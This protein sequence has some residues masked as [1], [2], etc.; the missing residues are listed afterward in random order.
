MGLPTISL[1]RPVFAIVMN[2][3]IVLFGII[4]Y[5][6]LGVREYPSIDP[7]VITV[8]TNYTGANADI[9]ETQITEPLEKAINGVE[10]I[11]TV[12][13]ASNQGSSIITV[14]F[15]LSSDLETAANDVRDKVSQA[16]RQLPQDIDAPPVV[17][18]ADANSDA[19]ISMTVQS[20]TRNI[21][22]LN[23]YAVNVLQ[24]R[25]QTIPGVSSV[26][27]WG[28]KNYSMRLWMDP[29]KM[30]AYGL[31]PLDIQ[32]ALNSENVELP[33]GKI[34]GSSVDLTVKTIG[35]LT[36]E[37][38]FNNLLLKNVNGAS[39]RLKDVGYATLGPENEE[40]SLKE[41][42]IPMVALALV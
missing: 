26:Q 2:I 36:T 15:D 27:I 29:Q 7:P 42:A 33:S 18:K 17:S 39:V 1:Q 22:E 20:N 12:S 8:R 30:A 23:D 3:V 35:R 14:E 41:S 40:T 13:S 10:G 4:G 6:F 11:R 32:N 9:I 38:E 28:Q 21:L 16:V 34:T 19:I 31:T 37:E 24:E 25:L 5:T